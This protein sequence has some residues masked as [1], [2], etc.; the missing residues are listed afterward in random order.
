MNRLSIIHTQLV[1]PNET[2][3]NTRSILY[4]IWIIEWIIDILIL[5]LT[6]C[7]YEIVILDNRVCQILH[8]IRIMS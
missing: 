6:F 7:S 3:A 1:R 4:Q 2:V 8:Q 5:T